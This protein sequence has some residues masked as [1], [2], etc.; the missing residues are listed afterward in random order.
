MRKHKKDKLH[1]SRPFPPFFLDKKL[2]LWCCNAVMVS[3]LCSS[4]LEFMVVKCRPFYLPRE[5]TASLPVTV[6]VPPSPGDSSELNQPS[7]HRCFPHPGSGFQPCWPQD[8]NLP[9]LIWGRWGVGSNLSRESQTSCSLDISSREGWED[10][11]AF[12]GQLGDIVSPTCP[13][14]S[15]GVSWASRGESDAQ[16]TSAGFFKLLTLSLR[17]PQ[18]SF[19]NREPQ[20]QKVRIH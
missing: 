6:H 10:S 7:A 15:P 11:K 12:P 2:E 5:F 3:K 20:P 9:L 4:L 1:T 19:Y 18:D 16:A 13:G 8:C 17:R 14:S